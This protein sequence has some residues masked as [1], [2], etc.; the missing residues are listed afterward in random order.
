MAAQFFQSP[1]A[2]MPR[3]GSTEAH[4][5]GVTLLPLFALITLRIPLTGR[6]DSAKLAPKGAGDK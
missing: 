2:G 3:L 6:R 4:L 5:G 1:A